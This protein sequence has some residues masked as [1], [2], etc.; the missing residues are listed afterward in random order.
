MALLL[1]C[2]SLTGC[3][4]TGRNERISDLC[5]VRRKYGFAT[6]TC[7]RRVRLSQRLMPDPHFTSIMK[8]RVLLGSCWHKPPY[9][10][11]PVV[12]EELIRTSSSSTA[13]SSQK[14]PLVCFSPPSTSSAIFLRWTG[15]NDYE[16]RLIMQLLEGR[17]GHGLG[18]SIKRSEE[19]CNWKLTHLWYIF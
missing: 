10:L 16:C 9:G 7:P 8:M 1:T 2:A 18:R 6:L 11:I 17:R 15:W 12:S 19:R 13:V 14:R 3:N 5:F 4:A